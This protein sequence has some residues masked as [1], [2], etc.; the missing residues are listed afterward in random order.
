MNRLL[1]S[2]DDTDYSYI[3]IWQDLN[4]ISTF[5]WNVEIRFKSCGMI[6]H[7]ML[8]WFLFAGLTSGVTRTQEVPQRMRLSWQ[9]MTA[10]PSWTYGVSM[11]GC[12]EALSAHTERQDPDVTPRAD[13]RMRSAPA[14]ILTVWL[15][16]LVVVM[17]SWVVV[18]VVPRGPFRA[19]SWHPV[20]AGPPLPVCVCVRATEN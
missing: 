13:S 15:A 19:P 8:D 18:R 14:I 4:L 7:L 10:M 5:Q 16:V 20:L 11:C 2:C 3:L 17:T 9:Q 1:Q 12:W 6:P